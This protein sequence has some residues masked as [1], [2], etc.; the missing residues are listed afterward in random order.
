MRWV[1]HVEFI[2]QTNVVVVQ[3]LREGDHFVDQRTEGRILL[4]VIKKLDESTWSRLNWFREKDSAVVKKQ[5][6]KIP[7]V[8]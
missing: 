2:G 8:V 3:Y 7:Q 4:K 1:E 5:V 6:V